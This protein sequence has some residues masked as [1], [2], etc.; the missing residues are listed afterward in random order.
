VTEVYDVVIVGAGPAGSVAAV[1]AARKGLRVGLVDKATFPRD[2]VCGDG[3]SPGTVKLLDSVG[4]A[5]VFDGCV[6]IREV[7]VRGVDGAR[8][9]GALPPVDGGQV[10]G[11]VIPRVEFDNRLFERAVAAGAD[12]L[13]GYTF[14][15][16]EP[17]PD[18]RTV[19]LRGSDGVRHVIRAR[20]LVGAD[21]AYSRVR[22]ELRVKPV[23]VQRSGVAMR[24]YAKTDAFDPH[25][26]IGPQLTIEFGRD[27][28]PG[29]GWIFPTGDGVV[30]VGVGI[31]VRDL[32]RRGLSLHELFHRYLS[33]NESRGITLGP[34]EDQR[35]HQ[36]P[37][38]GTMPRLVHDRAVLIG[39]AASMINPVSGE[40]IYYGVA[41]AVMLGDALP[42]DMQA[43]RLR[44]GMEGFEKAFRRRYRL[45]IGS[46]QI[47]Y[48][49]M[50]YPRW[51]S[52]VLTAAR[53]NSTVLRDALALLFGA[54]RI[55]LSTTVK[56][57]WYGLTKRRIDQGR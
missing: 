39:D 37:Q 52:I 40:G 19:E 46:V 38:F 21:G 15:A 12:D 47:A 31:A 2:K 25:G 34:L 57:F 4:L 41:A 49:M 20:L 24:A 6:P 50:R 23:D 10:Q 1:V 55:H 26:M 43:A 28:S 5:S 42:V 22:R 48:L 27:L 8:L 17:S 32:K 9:V 35:S 18:Y 30:N 33:I 14:V 11:Y 51:A 36:L 7:D 54:D 29:Y 53:N 16:T 56:I 45:H 3:V 44:A 13:T